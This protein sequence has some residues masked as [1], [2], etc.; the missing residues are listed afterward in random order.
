M[1]KTTTTTTSAMTMSKLI[2]YNQDHINVIRLEIDANNTMNEWSKRQITELPIET[3]I[4]TISR[5]GET[6]S[7]DSENL[8]SATGG[9]IHDDCRRA[10]ATNRC[11]AERAWE[12]ISWLNTRQK[13]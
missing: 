6:A 2:R 11:G 7:A 1:R 13:Y 9:S 12:L 5:V 10:S 8:A 4:Q 3:L